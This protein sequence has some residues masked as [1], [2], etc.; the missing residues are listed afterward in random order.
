MLLDTSHPTCLSIV[1]TQTQHQT[2]S[3][4]SKRLLHVCAACVVVNFVFPKVDISQPITAAIYWRLLGKS[5]L[6]SLS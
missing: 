4:Y 2:Y 6:A 3:E 5:K 1:S